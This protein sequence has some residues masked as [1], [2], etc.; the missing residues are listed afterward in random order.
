M[1][2]RPRMFSRKGIRPGWTET[3][4]PPKSYRSIFKYGDPRKFK[5]PGQR[6]VSMLKD[7]LGMPDQYFKG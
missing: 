3:P 2:G 5:H 4:P 6:W 1:K 7:E